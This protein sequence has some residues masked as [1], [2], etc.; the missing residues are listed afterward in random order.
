MRR[1]FNIYWPFAENEV[2][3]VLNYRYVFL[4]SIISGL[5]Q[6][7]VM[8][9]LWRAIF[10]SSTNSVLSGFT[11]SEM[12]IYIFISNI[13]SRLTFSNTDRIIGNDINKGS[14][15]MNLIL[16]LKYQT[17]LLFNAIGNHI[18]MLLTA[19]L[20]IWIC[21]ISVRF[22]VFREVPPNFIILLL[23]SI[24]TIFSFLIMFLLNFCFGMIAFYTNY[25]W[26][27]SVI[28]YAV[29]GILSG[30]II[31]IDFF[32]NIIQKILRILPF[33]YMNYIPVMIYLNKY[34]YFEIVFLLVKQLLWIFI[35]YLFTRLIWRKAEQNIT[36][37]GG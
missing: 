33:S 14:I 4:F 25:F 24:S 29:L 2:K 15:S 5:V 22:I 20:P 32:P 26:G 35:F 36:V 11:M 34:T 7:F 16:P 37:L 12:T 1:F 30:Q 3:R 21:F 8:Y 17:R 19:A 9:Y 13:T 27:A 28:K 10:K 18:Y 6:V 23:Y 31:P